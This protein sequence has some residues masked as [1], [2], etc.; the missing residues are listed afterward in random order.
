V[1]TAA[2]QAQEETELWFRAIGRVT[3]LLAL[4]VV[5]IAAIHGGA[6]E[7]AEIQRM[8][9]VPARE[10]ARATALRHAA[11][12]TAAGWIV[13]GALAM[14]ARAHVR[15]RRSADLTRGWAAVEPLWSGRRQPEERP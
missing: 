3:C 11:I 13:V 6:V 7:A 15:R 2:G 10:L 1:V 14:A 5:L 8:T 9:G 12:A 4:L